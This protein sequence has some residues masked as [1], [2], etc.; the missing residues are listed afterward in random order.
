[1][2]Y[3]DD[4]KEFTSPL[5]VPEIFHI[6]VAMST[7]SA[8]AQRKIWLD[9][10]HFK[11]TPNLYVIL[12]AEPGKCGKSTAMGVSKSLLLK[13]EK[14]KTQT[15]SI[16]MRKVYSTMEEART[17]FMPN[18]MADFHC[19]LT[20]F[21][22]EMGVLIKGGDKDFVIALNDLFDCQPVL[23]H[24]TQH[25]GTNVIPNPY[26]NILGCTTPDW[27]AQNLGADI[28]EGGFSAR[29]IF[30]FS[31]DVS[32]VNAF[33]EISDKGREALI[34]IMH[35]LQKITEL[36]GEVKFS[37]GGRAFYKMWYDN[38]YK[39]TNYPK[40][41]KMNGFHFRKRIHLL[42]CAILMSLAERDDLL[43]TEE[44]LAITL[45]L[46]E[47]TEPSIEAALKGVG[48]NILSPVAENIYL[49]V[50]TAKKISLASLSAS[51][52]HQCN[53]VEFKEMI[54]ALT[55]QRRIEIVYEEQTVNGVLNRVPFVQL[56]KGE[57]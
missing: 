26:L 6:W 7:L 11:V 1:M 55:Q 5:E 30:V 29:A 49:Q 34:R 14:V 33:P 15:G 36:E 44:D 46:L 28:V 20:L 41:P 16:T 42:K 43:I 32:K 39:P 8:C 2:P 45:Q 54:T 31:S 50:R 21:A 57:K 56:V 22:N 3:L 19:S 53:A 48:R 4:Y 13:L 18:G 17:P 27:I 38:F 24:S 51:N 40:N 10:G 35:R 25:H 12:D 47:I 37:P 52:Y 23:K 9:M